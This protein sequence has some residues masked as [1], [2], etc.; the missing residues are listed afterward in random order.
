MKKESIINWSEACNNSRR[1]THNLRI[2]SGDKCVKTHHA[3]RWNSNH[4]E[5]SGLICSCHEPRIHRIFQVD[6][7]DQMLPFTVTKPVTSR[8]TPI[9]VVSRDVN[10]VF[11]KISKRAATRFVPCPLIAD[12][13][14]HRPDIPLETP[15]ERLRVHDDAKVG[16]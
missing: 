6:H 13:P 1:Y 7:S 9:A 4:H 12:G 11:G 5:N 14:R 2:S 10:L 15:W 3:R 8:K 16:R